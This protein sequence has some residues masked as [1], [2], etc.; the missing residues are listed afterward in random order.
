[1]LESSALNIQFN[2]IFL[3]DVIKKQQSNTNIVVFLLRVNVP[4]NQ[5]IAAQ[6][7]SH[8]RS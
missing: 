5:R 7:L 1:M 3:R 2:C 8:Y 4:Y 6:Y